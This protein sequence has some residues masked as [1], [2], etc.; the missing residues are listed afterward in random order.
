MYQSSDEQVFSRVARVRARAQ[1]LMDGAGVACA[2]FDESL[3]EAE[4]LAEGIELRLPRLARTF[5]LDGLAVDALICLV[6]AEYDPY[7]R[8]LQR[9]LQRESGKPWLELGTV[10]ELLDLP[11]RRMPELQ[12]RF[13]ADAAL[14]RYSLVRV[15]D[16]GET[17]AVS[18]RVKVAERVAQFLVGGDGLPSHMTRSVQTEAYLDTL[19]PQ[20]TAQ[21]VAA[22]VRRALTAGEPLVV[23]ITGASGGG[24][25]RFAAHVAGVLQRPLITV[26]LSSLPAS[27]LAYALGEGE[28]EAHLAGALL[29]VA[30]WDAQLPAPAPVEEGQAAPPRQVPAVLR[31]FLQT[32]GGLVFLTAQEREPQLEPVLHVAVPFPSPSQR[33]QLLGR[34]L[35]TRLAIIAEEVDL[36]TVARRFALEPARLES[37]ARA[38]VDLSGDAPISC[39]S[40]SEAC[41]RQLRHD[42]ASVAVRVTASHRWEDLVIPVDVYEGLREM[43]AYVRHGERVYDDWG[44]GARHSL[45]RGISAL[46]SGPPG[47][48][49]TMCASVMARELDMELF[50]VDLSR[51]VSKWIGETEKNLGKVFDEA[52]RSNAIILFDE[53]DSLFAKRTEVKSS[54]DRYANLEVNFLLQKMEQFSGITI[55]T[56]NLDEG[57]D[58]AFRR[59]LTF[60]LRFERPDAEA[61]ASLWTKAFP[62]SCALA[63]DVDPMELGLRYEMSGGNIRNAAVRAAFLA[64]TEERVVDMNLCLLA[65]ERE[66]REMGLLVQ[67]RVAISELD[68]GEASPPALLAP[69]RPAHPPR[70]VPITHP[71]SA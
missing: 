32:Q 57:I 28:R 15:D 34:A 33:A 22:R 46:F 62:S 21:A 26:D 43:I 19:V 14:R 63:P 27:D 36:S 7:L 9:A 13:A 55:L 71:R 24:R 29:C 65:A 5:S 59:R 18:L 58:A 2:P 67:S 39:G 56:T 25:R 3:E 47:T 30:N 1:Q 54:V 53:A 61:R 20:P 40:L 42:L 68:D 38:A 69:L 37:A 17:P 50:R 4:A 8:L 45:S 12:R 64:A 70:L 23:E 31:R 51:V 48:G 35:E 52:S 60:R 66:C 44:F 41:R 10:A 6:A 49:K 11:L 16:L